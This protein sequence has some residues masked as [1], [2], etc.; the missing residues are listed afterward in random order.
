MLR[1]GIVGLGGMGRGRLHYYAQM[2][3][4]QVVAFADV[5]CE[6]LRRDGFL[7][8]LLKVPVARV[9]WFEDYRKLADSGVVDMVDICLPTDLHRD[10]AV[11]ALE[12]GLH[13]LCEKPMA[14]T[15]ADCDAMIEAGRKAGKLLMIAQ[16]I[17]FW[18]EYEVL[19]RM[20]QS[21][22]AGRLLSLQLTRQGTTPRG[23]GGWMCQAEHSGGAIL[24]LHIHDIDYCQ[25]LLGIPQ[26]VYAKGGM[27]VSRDL[28]YDYALI[29]LD[30][31]NGLQ[32]CA[33]TH[34]T[35]VPIPFVARYEA[36]FE[37][38]FLS[39]DSG[40]TPSLIIYRQGA[41]QP[42]SPNLGTRDAYYNEIRYFLDCVL[43][44]SEPKRCPPQEARNSIALIKS[45]VAS[46]ERGELVATREFVV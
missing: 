9:H 24:D 7:E 4:A 14:L 8:A 35:S 1:V 29:N 28:G 44:G 39:C 43:T 3:D 36:R 45:A 21:G 5:R 19:T 16:C 22:E 15:L 41:A 42:E 25:Y 6:E 20:Y 17:R 37:R 11:A 18:P 33:A 13:V 46:I 10:A 23:G 30:Y 27:S 38:A 32:V 40:R 31:G 26:R 2:P 12:G 34:W